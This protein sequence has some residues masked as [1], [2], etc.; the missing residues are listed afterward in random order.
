MKTK[1][2]DLTLRQ[3]IEICNKHNEHCSNCPLFYTYYDCHRFNSKYK[4]LT[5]TYNIERLMKDEVELDE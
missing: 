5:E 1:L 2:I 3:I 4:T